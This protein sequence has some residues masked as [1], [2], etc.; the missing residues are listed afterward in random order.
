MEFNI[1]NRKFNNVS[2]RAFVTTQS[3][4]QLKGYLKEWALSPDGWT[5]DGKNTFNI[6]DIDE[7]Q[8]KDNTF[9]KERWINENDLEQRLIVTYSIKYRNY[10]RQIREEQISRALKLIESNPKKVEKGRQTDYK[11]LITKTA[12]TFDGEVASKKIYSIDEELIANEGKYDGFYGVCT[13]LVDNVKEIIKINKRRWEI[14]ESFRIMKTEFKT[15]PV[16]LSNDDRIRAHFTS[17]FIALVVYRILECKLE[18]KYTTDEILKALKSMNFLKIKGEGYIPTYT[19]TT[20]TDTLHETFEFRTDYQIV[21][22]QSMK[23]ILNSTKK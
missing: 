9:Y 17:C 3:I 20:L 11:R 13:N 21:D 8:F 19:R 4:K 5:L 15:R 14:E 10:H 18:S 23:T 6:N 16:Y 12:V 22:N 2:D 1:L 7:E